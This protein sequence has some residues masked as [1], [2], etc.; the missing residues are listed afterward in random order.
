MKRVTIKEVAKKSGVSIS[1]VSKVLNNKGSISETTKQKIH[2]AVEELNYNVNANARNLKANSSHKVA[3]LISSITNYYLMSIAKEI[4]NTIRSLGYHMILLSHDDNPKIE[5]EALKIIIEE[6]VSALIIIPTGENASDLELFKRY[7]VPV[8]VIDREVSDYTSNLVTED[9]FY[10]S[11]ES[12]KYLAN[13]N[14]K[15][16]GILMGHLKNS[17]GIDRYEGTIQA[18]HDFHLDKSYELIKFTDFDDQK[19]Y[20]ATTELLNLSVPPTAI[21]A[22]NNTIA[23]GMIR[24]LKDASIQIPEQL[25]IIFYGNP[26]QWTLVEPNFTM[27]AQSVDVL[28]KEASELL[29]EMLTSHRVDAFSVVRIK[30]E[31]VIGESVKNFKE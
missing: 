23:Q 11:Y 31:L 8:V 9:H 25:S 19:A 2:N 7:G 15:R 4:E 12:M 18:I 30:P 20:L 14:H 24:A 29:K 21:F 10:G 22:C 6:D 13:N 27:M 1:T 5:K 3:L 28:S 16:I 17:V 26:K